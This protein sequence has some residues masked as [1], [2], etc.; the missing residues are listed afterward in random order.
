MTLSDVLSNP[1]RKAAFLVDASA[2][3]DAEVAKKTGL[4]GLAL[5][6]GLGAVRAV[7][8]DIV[9]AALEM[10]LPRF[11]PAVEPLLVQAESSGDVASW[12]ADHSEQVADALLAVTDERAAVAENAVLR[13][14][15]Q[16]LRGQAHRHTV[17]AVPAVGRL[18]ARYTS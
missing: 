11:A 10:L 12:F 16:S 6:T 9:S 1:P 4:T 8:P 7:R 5:R 3:V 15:Y 14:T 2:L 13:K 17:E 18:L